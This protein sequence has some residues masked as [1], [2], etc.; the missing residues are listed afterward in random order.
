MEPVKLRLD[1]GHEHQ[2][3]F[4]RLRESLLMGKADTWAGF[5]LFFLFSVIL[6]LLLAFAG[7]GGGALFVLSIIA[8][9]FLYAIFVYPKFGI[10]VLLTLSYLLFVLMKFG[11]DFPMG[12][13]VDGLEVLLLFGL[14]LKIK[15]EK[16]WKIFRG[17]ISAVILMWIGYNL[18]EVINPVA[19]SRLAWLYTVRS[20][21][22]LMLVYFIFIY[23]IRSASFIRLI[24]KLWLVL[25][26]IGAL[27]GL[28]Q[29]F[30]GFSAS[31]EA[32][33]NSDPDIAALLFIDGHWRIFSIYSDPVAFSYNMIVS[34]ILCISLIT[35]PL[36]LKKKLVLASLAALFLFS[37]FYSG[38]RSAYVLLP[39]A[40]LLLSILKF[41]RRVMTFMVA[42]AAFFAVL[43]MVPTSH[44]QLYR[45][46]TAFKPS[47]DASFN[48]RKEN[49]KRIQPYILSHP[50]GGGL[51]ATGVWGQRFAPYSFLANFPPDSG[52]VRV[53]VEM[54]WMGLLL[55]CV[56]MFTILYTGIRNYYQ[57]RDPELK[58]Y[59][60][61]M[62]LIVFALNIG[63]YP[64]EALVQFP[65]N[66]YFYLVVALI[67]VTKVLDERKRKEEEQ[68][69]SISALKSN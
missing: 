51:G 19:E 16:D 38:T 30:L 54:G 49:Q 64:Q 65:S 48:V 17:P 45:F 7:V 6:S 68:G 61:A 42:A 22:M 66:I 26:V 67:H 15:E 27:Y 11:L 43:I 24:I 60:L 58:T 41:N 2:G 69:H 5:A 63:N 3:W 29:E 39:A 13:L 44:P 56:L 12:T 53:A 4:G 25:S 14:L 50:M 23:H 18:I 36:A 34:S 47:D 62:V 37:M 31:E 35:G 20:V 40:L 55:F 8:L 57:I 59:C 21:A 52:Y 9:P 10:L 32:W 46:Q 1:T 33:L 28:K